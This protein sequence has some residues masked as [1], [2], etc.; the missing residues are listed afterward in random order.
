M[1]INYLETWPR[2]DNTSCYY[3]GFALLAQVSSWLSEVVDGPSLAGQVTWPEISVT[4]KLN[5]IFPNVWEYWLLIAKYLHQNLIWEPKTSTLKYFG[6]LWTSPWVKTACLGENWLSKKLPKLQ[7]F[8]QSGHT[9]WN[10]T[11]WKHLG[12]FCEIW[13]F[14]L[15]WTKCCTIFYNCN[16]WVFVI[17]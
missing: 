16:L 12:S 7:N 8:A 1:W 13:I 4:R 6:N 10:A 14:D 3:T 15:L 9:A 11:M 5:K 17:S 2:S